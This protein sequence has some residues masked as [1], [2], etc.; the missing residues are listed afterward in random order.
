[1][2]LKWLVSFLSLL[3]V[4]AIVVAGCSSNES[5]V[6]AS[7]NT[8]ASQT[9]TTRNAAPGGSQN[10]SPPAIDWAAAAAKLNVTEQ[11]L[12]DA[13]GDGTQ[14]GPDLASA[15]AKLG[16]T[17]DALQEALGIPGEPPTGQD[18]GPP[19]NAPSAG[20]PGTSSNSQSVTGNA[21]YAQ[22][23][24]TFANANQT[25]TASDQNESAVK[26][27]NGGIYTLTDS[28]IST[29][30]DSS[31]LDSSSF[32]G[33]NAAVLAQS[34]S[35]ISLSGVSVNTTGSGANGVF[36][37]GQGS[38]IDL[39]DVQVTCMNT[40]AHGVDAT[41][42]GTL[43]LNNV[44][45]TT[46]GNGASAAIATDR[47]GGTI[48]VNG[49]TATTTG[50]KSPPIY[51]TGN[52]TATGATMKATASEAVVIEGKNS[53]TLQDTTISGA[54][55]WGVLIYQS[56]SGD[57]EI[58]TGN[59]RMTGGTLTAEQGPL[60]YCTNTQAAITLNDATLVNSSGILLRASAGDWGTEGSNG[61]D[62]VLSADQETLDGSIECDN[63]SSVEITL[64]KNTV[65]SGAVNQADTAKS[66]ALSL[67]ATSTWEVIGDS[68]VT[69]FVD[70]DGSLSNVHS[71]GHT[72]YYDA[73]NSA[74][75]WLKGSTYALQGGGELTPA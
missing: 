2:R 45:I 6:T 72:V 25:V 64:E 57:A 52:I 12:R 38:T 61:A 60:F 73:S 75:S 3:A 32:Y 49:G 23:G 8:T 63:L 20:E 53:V 51:S 46:S 19:S 36:A 13:M 69:A 50:T 11:Q 47:G 29:A 40:G 1:M 41:L 65:L 28:R 68:H 30:G 74:N 70:A 14:N 10:M 48:T 27:S 59:F 43:N 22:G 4:S 54:I 66:V 37:T 62:V 58:G 39:N 33:L 18:G 24:G 56:M 55:N 26:V 16:V 17:Q 35:K 44:D 7:A 15:A 9:L 71:N 34:G 5:A 31:S 42:G 21:T 67:D